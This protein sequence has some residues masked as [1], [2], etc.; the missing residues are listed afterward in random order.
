MTRVNL[1]LTTSSNLSTSSIYPREIFFQ[2]EEIRRKFAA[3]DSVT[4]GGAFRLSSWDD[5]SSNRGLEAYENYATHIFRHCDGSCSP[6]LDDVAGL[7]AGARNRGRIVAIVGRRRVG[8][9]NTRAQFRATRPIK[10]SHH[11]RS[12][13]ASLYGDVQRQ[14][15][16][17]LC[18][19]ESGCQV[20]VLSSA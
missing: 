11:C 7:V 2:V 14:R 20:C 15:N 12:Q 9:V 8:R 1:W 13:Y 4:R 10:R 16:D 18:N 5:P 17:R 6:I 3:Y 19:Q